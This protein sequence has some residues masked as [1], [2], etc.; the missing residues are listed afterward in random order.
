M[1]FWVYQ[2]YVIKS[3]QY[4]YQFNFHII[5]GGF[6]CLSCGKFTARSYRGKG[7][8]IWHFPGESSSPHRG[9]ETG[10]LKVNFVLQFFYI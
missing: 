8:K 9:A 7:L 3:K 5:P 10:C 2:V 6:R 1:C 4:I